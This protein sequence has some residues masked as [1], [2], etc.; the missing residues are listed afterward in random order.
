MWVRHGPVCLSMRFGTQGVCGTQDVYTVQSVV[1]AFCMERS[2]P[3]AA[4]GVPVLHAGH[5]RSAG[6]LPY[7][8]AADLSPVV[9][10]T[11]CRY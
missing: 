9:G 7:M 11:E 8:W 3:L 6:W 1:C 10:G 5:P 4:S 2:L